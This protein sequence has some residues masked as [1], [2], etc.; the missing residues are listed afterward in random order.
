LIAHRAR[1]RGQTDAAFDDA[2]DVM[3]EVECLVSRRAGRCEMRL[4]Q[5]IACFC[6]ASASPE[7]RRP[8]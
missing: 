5:S 2:F 8:R 6:A 1:G 4:R 3:N 7:R